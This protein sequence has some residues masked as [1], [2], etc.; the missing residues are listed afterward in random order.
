MGQGEAKTHFNEFRVAAGTEYYA[1]SW[2]KRQGLCGD[3]F[4]RV[5]AAIRGQLTMATGEAGIHGSRSRP[6]GQK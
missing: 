5:I 4:V 2:P 6:S 3:F 1:N